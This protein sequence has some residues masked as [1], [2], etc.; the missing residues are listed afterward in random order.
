LLS[1]LFGEVEV[2]EEHEEYAGWT[3]DA[4]PG[5]KSG[6]RPTLLTI[7]GQRQLTG[8]RGTKAA[9]AALPAALWKSAAWRWSK[10]AATTT[11]SESALHAALREATNSGATETLRRPKP[12]AEPTAASC[13]ESAAR[14]GPWTAGPA[15]HAW[16]A[17]RAAELRRP[18]IAPLDALDHFFRCRCSRA[19]IAFG[20]L[21][22]HGQGRLAD[23]HDCRTG[24][25]AH[26]VVSIS[27]FFAENLH[28]GFDSW[29]G[30]GPSFGRFLAAFF[31]RG[32]RRGHRR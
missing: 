20:K 32:L 15:T 6:G 21:L 2:A 17:W 13:A 14:H 16:A 29:V 5:C 4:A 26:V 27:H 7:R 18:T 8:A 25:V 1:L 11:T 9:G 31:A 12:S 10:A 23:G 28:P 22:Q 24:A 3:G 30:L 19:I